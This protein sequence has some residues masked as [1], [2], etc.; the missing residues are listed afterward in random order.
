MD[1]WKENIK[2]WTKEQFIQGLYL[3]GE[4][5]GVRLCD[6]CDTVINDDS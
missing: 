2:D 1:D 4:F 5:S 6:N 3:L